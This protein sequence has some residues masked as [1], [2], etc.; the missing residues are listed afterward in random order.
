MSDLPKTFFEK[1]KDQSQ[2]VSKIYQ[3]RKILPNKP[4]EEVLRLAK[5]EIESE[6]QNNQ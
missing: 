3:I 4:I 1:I 5:E 2:L 6:K